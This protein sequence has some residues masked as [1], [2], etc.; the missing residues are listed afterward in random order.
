MLGDHRAV[1]SLVSLLK[2]KESVVRK[3]AARSLGQLKDK[4]VLPYLKAALQ[5]ESLMVRK[6]VEEAISDIEG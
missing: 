3:S 6:H 5:D 2:D 4:N 1:S